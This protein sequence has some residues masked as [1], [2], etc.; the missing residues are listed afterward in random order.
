MTISHPAPRRRTPPAP[1]PAP[2]AKTPERSA[3]LYELGIEA[4]SISGEIAIA[5]ELLGSDDPAEQQQAIELMES[6][7]LAE[8]HNRS[9]LEAK[10]DNICAYIDSISAKAA[11]RKAEAQRLADLAAAD[12]KRAESLKA[13]MLKVLTALNPGERKFSLP[14]HELVSRATESIEIEDPDLIPEDLFR[15]TVR[16]EPD[17]TQIKAAIKGG[18]EVPGASLVRKTSWTIK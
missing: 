4:Q 6:Y 17:K 1:K 2:L 10:A 18:V 7:L 13:Y 11:F 9:A 16:R 8:E 14:L 5:A 15:T 3:S 12:A